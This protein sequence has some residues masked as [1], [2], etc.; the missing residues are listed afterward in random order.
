MQ[1]LDGKKP[2][3][4]GFSYVAFSSYKNYRNSLTI[5]PKIKMK[6]ETFTAIPG[7]KK[8]ETNGKFVRGSKTKQILTVKAGTKKYQLFNDAGKRCL[9]TLEEINALVNRK[10]TP[11]TEIKAYTK[12]E[13]AKIEKFPTKKAAGKV[14]VKNQKP[15][16]L[17][18]IYEKGKKV[19]EKKQT[20][21]EKCY[22]LHLQG[23]TTE[24]IMKATGCPRN[25]VTRNIWLYTS[26]KKVY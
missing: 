7:F 5:K 22:Y 13:H 21:T 2:G 11:V 12:K 6:T 15:A 1:A 16:S 25:A 4:V 24:Q 9:I 3:V 23:K 17:N 20:K 10:P 18:G 8:A 14:L 19:G 26:G